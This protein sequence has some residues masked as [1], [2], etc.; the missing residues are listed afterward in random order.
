[1]IKRSCDNCG[2]EIPKPIGA[3][4]AAVYTNFKGYCSTRH[5][6]EKCITGPYKRLINVR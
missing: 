1:M 5:Y 3:Y 2:C 6:C 4:G